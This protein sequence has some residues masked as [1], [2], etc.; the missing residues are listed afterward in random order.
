MRVEQ[1][2]EAERKKMQEQE[3][4]IHKIETELKGKEV[5]IKTLTEQLETRETEVSFLSQKL[6]ELS[7][8][9]HLGDAMKEIRTYRDEKLRANRQ[10][11]KLV[12]NDAFGSSQFNILL[13]FRRQR[14]MSCLTKMKSSSLK[15]AT[16]DNS[17]KSQRISLD[18][19]LKLYYIAL[20]AY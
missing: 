1:G 7:A 19:T 20:C 10:I 8:D 11:Q 18:W 5:F 2:L 13:L 4:Y 9:S 16:S 15:S 3:N 17:Q 12:K 6:R 14:L